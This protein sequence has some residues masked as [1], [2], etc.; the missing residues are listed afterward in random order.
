MKNNCYQMRIPKI[1]TA[2]MRL[3]AFTKKPLK[4]PLSQHNSRHEAFDHSLI[5]LNE[6]YYFTLSQIHQIR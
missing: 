1:P 2:R 5:F 3:K 4:I 6:Q